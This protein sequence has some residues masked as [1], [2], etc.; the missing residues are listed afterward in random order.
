MIN[1]QNKKIKLYKIK[2]MQSNQNRLN[3]KK[4]QINKLNRQVNL[5]AVAL[6]RKI[7]KILV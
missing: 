3:L 6:Q 1:K 2:L 7:Y 5:F 4:K